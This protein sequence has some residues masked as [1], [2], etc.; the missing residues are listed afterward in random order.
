MPAPV[1]AALFAALVAGLAAPASAA[2]FGESF[3]KHWGDGRAEIS[4]YDLTY[5]R[6][7]ELREGTAV[8]IFVTETFSEELRVKADPGKHAASDEFPV[9]KLNLV[10]DFPTGIYDYQLMTSTFAGLAEHGGRPEGAVAK[11]SF[12]SQE[13]CGHVWAQLLP[14]ARSVRH[15][16]YSYFDGEA[17]RSE[18]LPVPQGGGLLE[19][20]VLLWARGFA[21]PFLAPGEAQE[22]PVL[23]SMELA[24]LQHFPVGWEDAVL[25]RAGAPSLIDVPAGS[26]EVEP[27]SVDLDGGRSWNVFV[28]TA[29]PRRIIRWTTSDGVL[30]ELVKTRRLQYW[31]MNASEFADSLG[32]IGLSPRPR[33]TP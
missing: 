25:S 29:E 7:G 19:D 3:W 22:I 20:A 16:S 8:T 21:A 30:A 24:R 27:V 6:Y 26:F 9:M 17:D 18:E 31:R 4:T 5:P 2:R 1:R 10:Q 23:R 12:S 28:E 15:V 32:A 11:V 13:W 14:D 33:R